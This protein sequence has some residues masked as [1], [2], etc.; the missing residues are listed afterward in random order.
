MSESTFSSSIFDRDPK[1]ALEWLQRAFGFELT[2]LIESPDGDVRKMHA[3]MSFAGRGRVMVG[4][5][6]AAW[7]KS[8]RSVQGANTQ[9][10]HVQLEEDLDAHC[11]RARNA[12]AVIVAEPA[13]QFFGA[14]TYRAL[15]LEGH[16]WTFSR[17]VRAVTREEAERASGL[18]IRADDWR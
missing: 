16:V 18:S 11:E 6:W 12:G 10:L 17:V 13:D 3:E 7:A 8:P 4:A 14:R 15:D 2:M 5:E 9:S 1:V